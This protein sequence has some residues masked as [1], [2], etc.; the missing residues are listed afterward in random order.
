MD[1]KIPKVNGLDR[2][3]SLRLVLLGEDAFDFLAEAGPTGHHLES[4]PYWGYALYHA[5][6]V[7]LVVFIIQKPLLILVV[8]V[9]RADLYADVIKAQTVSGDVP[10]AV[11]L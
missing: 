6:E 9:V 5:F 8:H 4:F 10:F 1:L 7:G 2:L 11:E 3:W